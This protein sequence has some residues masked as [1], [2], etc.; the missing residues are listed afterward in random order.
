MNLRSGF[1]LRG[2]GRR[3]SCIQA[4][5]GD[6]TVFDMRACG[7]IKTHQSRHVWQSLKLRGVACRR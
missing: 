2:S 7:D 1:F 6:L 3:S 4:I 5:T